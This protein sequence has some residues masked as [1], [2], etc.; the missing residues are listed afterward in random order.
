MK[1]HNCMNI[2]V[3][4]TDLWF[5]K[6]RGCIFSTNGSTMRVFKKND[7]LI[8][9]ELKTG[10]RKNTKKRDKMPRI[11]SDYSVICIKNG[12]FTGKNQPLTI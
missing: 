9:W 4:S 8:F 3:N 6:M 5:P 10:T 11:D 1:N 12:N 7:T 2:T